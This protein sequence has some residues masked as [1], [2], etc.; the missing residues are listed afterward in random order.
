MAGTDVSTLAGPSGLL[1]RF[2]WQTL[3]VAMS[4]V[5]ALAAVR[6]IHRGYT[7]LGDNALVELRSRDVFTRDHPL[8]GTGS[9]ASVSAGIDVNHPGPLLF[10][11]LAIPIR[12]FGSGAGIASTVAVIHIVT[13]WL[14][15][16]V[17]S[18]SFGLAAA[19]VGQSITAGLIWTLG[20]ELLYDPWQPNLLVLPFWFVVCCMWT[21][22]DGHLRWLPL[23]VGYGS[24]AMQTHLSYIF[25]VPGLL[26]GGVA[27]AA[28]TSRR[29][30][31]GERISFRRPLTW[32]IVV[33]VILWAQPL[34]EQFFGAGRGNLTRLVIAGTGG[35]G[36]APESVL[37]GF[38]VGTRIL[39]AVLSLPP[40][41]GRPGYDET[42]TG[43]RF[44]DGDEGLLLVPTD[45]PT[46]GIAVTSLAVLTAIVGTTW[47]L[48]SR[49]NDSRLV[50]GFRMI[51][52]FGALAAVTTYFSPID[53]IGL[54]PHKFRP[55]WVLGAFVTV[56]MVLSIITLVDAQRTPMLVGSVGLVGVIATVMTI[57]YHAQR[58]GP[59]AATVVSEGVS[60]IRHQLA[61]YLS[62]DPPEARRVII[63]TKIFEAGSPGFGFNQ[64]YTSA[65]IAELAAGGVDLVT[66]DESF[67]RQIGSGRRFDG[68]ESRS[69]VF[70]R[71]GG[72][73][74]DPNGAR[75]IAFHDGEDT[76]FAASDF[77]DRAVA[78]FIRPA[79][80]PDGEE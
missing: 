22:A 74:R 67:P 53:A 73:A 9:S 35:E 57:P 32:S 51:A 6:G 34:V 80:V 25:I 55:L 68:D 69:V 48:V 13:I 54:T 37:A 77:T 56:M 38:R 44:V 18:R 60:E 46:F 62:S 64:P 75:R 49:R 39:A 76:M 23:A 5:I 15:G 72:D 19:V 58:S 17:V 63:D 45:L 43:S 71:V 26:V 31:T 79:R 7:P 14:I 11:L 50:A 42:A 70:V 65:V 33:I 52:V 78:V 29:S 24:F 59:V 21:V 10:D 40:F 16:F 61:E 4:F 2:A 47:R 20:S 41:W 1:R 30:E 12:L 8:L 36:D 66:T 27:L 28:L 3:T